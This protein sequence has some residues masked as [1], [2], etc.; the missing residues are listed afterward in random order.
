[1]SAATGTD[2]RVLVRLQTARA[3]TTRSWSPLRLAI[4]LVF[5]VAYFYP[6]LVMIGTAVRPAR[7]YVRDPTGLPTTFTLANLQAAWSTGDLGR[8]MLNSL[9]ASSIGTVICCFA[10]ATAG[11]W[12][13][14]HT[15][16]LSRI[17]LLIFGSLWVVPLVVYLVPLYVLL[18]QLHLVN[19]L[20]TLG[21]V[22][23]AFA[24]PGALWLV[25]AYL[26][27]GIPLELL[28]AA[29]MDGASRLQQFR[30]VV[31]PLSTPIMGAIAAL[32]F[33]FC[34]SDLLVA[35]VVLNDPSKYTVVPAA[36][37]LVSRFNAAVQQTAAAGLITILPSLVVFLVAQ[38][39]IVRG[40]V[41]GFSR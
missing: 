1:M 20:I 30:R 10:C 16:R 31:L 3:S 9:V 36:A 18:S 38:R 32:A 23:G 11:F 27:Q 29:E 37:T 4:L 34:W 12:F 35:V 7:D 2:R 28:E 13:L 39:A 5:T 22:Y 8:A 26:L 6:L 25:W 33:I 21:V 14:L 41:T 19:N 15:S 17:I 40:I 24:T